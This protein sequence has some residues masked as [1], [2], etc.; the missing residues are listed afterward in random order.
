[1]KRAFPEIQKITL[2][3]GIAYKSMPHCGREKSRLFRM[4]AKTSAVCANIADLSF[5]I[6]DKCP[7]TGQNRFRRACGLSPTGAAVWSGSGHEGLRT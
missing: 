3:M 1:M 7:P 6:R 5:A 2:P 4:L